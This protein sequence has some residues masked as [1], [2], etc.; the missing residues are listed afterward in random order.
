MSSQTPRR[1]SVNAL[2]LS[3]GMVGPRQA[4]VHDLTSEFRGFRV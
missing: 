2:D 1:A 4:G 3:G